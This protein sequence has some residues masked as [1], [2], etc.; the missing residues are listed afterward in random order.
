MFEEFR[1]LSE[2]ERVSKTSGGLYF[3]RL[4]FPSDFE[5]GIE[6]AGDKKPSVER[7]IAIAR[8]YFLRASE[9]AMPIDLEGRLLEPDK[10]SHLQSEFELSATRRQNEA[11]LQLLEV[12]FTKAAHSDP[13]LRAV[14]R[15]TRLFFQHLPVAYVGMTT[16]Q[17]LYDRLG[18]HINDATGFSKR[19]RA[20]G[21]GWNDLTFSALELPEFSSADVRDLE[22]LFQCLVRPTFSLA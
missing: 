10:A 14:L 8:E 9:L 11:L 4:R 13:Q 2:H 15:A 7:I 16:Q 5:L 22:K 21:Y 3:F 6:W 20:R 12:S 19:L 17:S 18:Q 1:L